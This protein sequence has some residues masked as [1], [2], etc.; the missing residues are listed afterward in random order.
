MNES[1]GQVIFKSGLITVDDCTTLDS[2]AKRFLVP[3]AI[4]EKGR[5][6]LND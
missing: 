4:T 3:I 5:K 1:W 6:L 2:E